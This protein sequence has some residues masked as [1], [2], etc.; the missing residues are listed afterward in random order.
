MTCR[1]PMMVMRLDA[2][3][4]PLSVDTLGEQTELG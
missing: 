1:V 2:M 3:N 4:R